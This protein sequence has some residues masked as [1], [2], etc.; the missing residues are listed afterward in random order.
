MFGT[1]EQSDYELNAE[2]EVI[3]EIGSIVSIE[4]EA[5]ENLK[6]GNILTNSLSEENNY[7]SSYENTIKLDIS[8][9]EMIKNLE[10]KD[11]SEEFENESEKVAMNSSKI[12]KMEK[13][14]Y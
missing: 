1:N 8:L 6:Y 2:Y 14:K 3:E 7:T 4:S 13:L 5:Q 12:Q 11:E 9:A 10:I